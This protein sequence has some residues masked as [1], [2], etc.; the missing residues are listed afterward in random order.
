MSVQ[1]LTIEQ[2]P[3]TRPSDIVSQARQSECNGL[4]Q[5]LDRENGLAQS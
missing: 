4:A 5:N 2:Y 1:W 3:T